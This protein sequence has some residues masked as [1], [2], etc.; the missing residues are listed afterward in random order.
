MTVTEASRRPSVGA[1]RF[2]YFVAL[3]LEAALLYLLNVRPGWG[4]LPF[5]TDDMEQVIGLL[6]VSIVV[7]MAA[8]ALYLVHDP[9]WLKALGDLATT[10]VGI[11]V[12]VRFWQVFPFDFGDASFD[13]ALLARIMIVLG[14]IGSAIGLVVALVRLVR[15]LG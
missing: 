7:G 3:L 10:G 5:L 6:N 11:A 12:L 14:I 1:R 4:V 8:N 15:N 2:G 9:A 13:W